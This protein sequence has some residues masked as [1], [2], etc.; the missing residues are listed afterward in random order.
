MQQI[1]KRNGSIVDFDIK[2]IENA[3]KKAMME[4]S[5]GIEE[6]LAKNI[7]IKIKSKLESNVDKRLYTVEEIQ[8]L[9]EQLLMRSNRYDVAKK[10]ILYREHRNNL[11]KAPAW[12]MTELQSAI[13]DNKYRYKNEDFNSFLN[14]I[15]NNNEEFKK[16]I[17]NKKFLPA[18]RILAGRGTNKDGH[19]VTLSNCFVLKQPE[20][21]LE[22]IF[23]T[24]KEMARTY[25]WGGGVGIDISKLR[26][27]NAKVNNSARETTGAISFMDLYSMTTGL[28][29]QHNR[30][31]ALMIS[32]DCH[33]PDIIE[34]IKLKTDLD[35]VTKANISVKL[36]DAFFKAVLEDNNW[37]MEFLVK[38]TGE[39]ITK[40][41]KAN[42]ILHLF[43]KCNWGYA[44]PGALF[45]DRI[46]HWN[47]LSEDKEF[48]YEGVNP[49]AEEPL[50]AYGSCNLSSINLSEFVV[51]PFMDNS[52]FDFEKFN[53]TVRLVVRY[54]NDILDEAVEFNMYPLEKQ[55]QMA[56][57]YRQIGIGAMGIADMLIKLKIRYGSKESLNICDK[58]G[59]EMI[60]SALQESALLAKENGT[61]LKYNK[62]AILKSDFLKYN[63]YPKTI[64]MIEQYGLRN[65]QLLTLAPTGSIS[66]MLGISG[67][68]EPIY[69]Y[70][71]TR[72]TESIHDEDVYYKVYTPI[73]EEYMKKFNI[74]DEKDLPDYFT[75]AMLLNPFERIDMQSV[76]QTHIDA[77]ISSTLNLPLTTSV[78]QVEALYIYGWEKGLKGMTIYRDGCKR[79]GILSNE[80]NK[81]LN[82]IKGTKCPECGEEN[83]IKSNGCE[84]CL[85]CGFSPCSV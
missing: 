61:Y 50:P 14:R 40:E 23:D 29:G 59:F 21:N 48:S 19:K 57:D 37:K 39:I 65:S 55:K 27:A 72:K 58:I 35:K 71:Y 17:L 22:S 3:I 33:H 68:I 30:R 45:W 81:D 73:V 49:C 63:A 56:N 8:D 62:E 12:E 85:N 84:L 34:F 9:V 78:S 6:S 76:W 74:T 20:D 67:G 10:Y 32:M 60:N 70:S 16:A 53:E 18:G 52:Y 13:L 15:S 4:T 77:S 44:E 80:G 42:E 24:A 54:M 83:M 28:I 51:N 82:I 1:V 46:S 5:D 47:L 11:R 79:G 66:T 7:S 38:D 25:S 26:P 43:A 75:N 64:E 36:T 41:V 31:G 69:N 2:R